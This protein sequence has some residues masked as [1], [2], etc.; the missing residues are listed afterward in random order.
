MLFS[1]NDCGSSLLSCGYINLWNP[2][3]LIQASLDLPRTLDADLVHV[4][5][6]NKD[7]I[8]KYILP[9]SWPSGMYACREDAASALIKF[10]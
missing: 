8:E 10:P 2:V 3:P 7:G 6:A 4:R 9:I 5:T 1:R